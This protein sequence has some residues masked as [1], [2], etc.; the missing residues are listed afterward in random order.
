MIKEFWDERAVEY[1]KSMQATLR[2][3]YLRKL[4]I[5]TML[6]ILKRVNPSLVLEIGCGNGYSTFIYAKMFPKIKI[7]AT[8]YSEAM[9]DIAKE[10]YERKNIGYGVWDITQPHEFPFET[11]KFDFI[12]S[13]RVIQNLPSWEMQRKA[14]ND[15]INMLANNG[16]LCIMECSEEGVNQLNKWRTRIGRR[17]INGI[18]PWHNKFIN[19]LKIKEE[20]SNNLNKIIYFS[21]TYMFI[22]RLIHYRLNKIAWLLPSFGNFGYDRIYIFRH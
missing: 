5:K 16:Q 12:F 4:E 7:I 18:I 6:K 9:I 20:F 10:N 19:D 21:S 17:T 22:T 2:E 13:Q 15:L 1:G 11:T 8:D 14:I 3:V